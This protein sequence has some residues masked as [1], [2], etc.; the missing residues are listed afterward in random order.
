MMA[1]RDTTSPE[2]KKRMKLSDAATYLGVSAAKMSRLIGAGRLSYSVDPLDL[3][4]KLV[5]VEDL[6]R[7]K[8]QSLSSEEEEG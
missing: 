2:K 8:E 3:R 5:L 4:R 7:I 6:D 1:T